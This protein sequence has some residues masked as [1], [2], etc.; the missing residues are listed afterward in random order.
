MSMLIPTES[1]EQC[2]LFE[3][4]KVFEDQYPELRLLFH[5]PNGGLRNKAT[6]VRLVAEGVRSGVPDLFLPVARKGF[7]GLFIEMKK[8]R[9]GALTDKQKEWIAA[10]NDQGYKAVVCYGWDDARKVIEEYLGGK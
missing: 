7:H 6:A 5:V 1:E 2:S 8:K 4:A 9:G 3:W 10:L